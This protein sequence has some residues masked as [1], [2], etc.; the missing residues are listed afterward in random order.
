MMTVDVRFEASAQPAAGGALVVL[1]GPDG[2]LS[3]AARAADEASG[4]QLGRAI[5]AAGFA[6]KKGQLVEIVAPHGHAA[7]RLLLAGMGEPA[8]ADTRLFEDVGGAIAARLLT[9]TPSATVDLR[10]LSGLGT[11][12]AEAAAHLGLGAV[13]RAWRHDRYRTR[14][15]EEDKPKL[16]SLAIVTEAD[17]AAR[18]ADLKEVAAGVFLARELV[19][20]PGNVIYPDSFVE[21]VR[22]EVELL[23]V[24]V[25]VLDVP[26]MERLGMWSLLS[27]GQGSAK[28]ARLLAM[29]WMGGPEGAK[30]LALIGKGVTFDTGGISLKPA[31]N[32]EDMRTDMG[33]AAAVAGA[34]RALAGRKAK[35]NVVGVCGLVENMPSDRATRPGDVVTSLSG[36]TVEIINTDAEGRL[37]LIDTMTWTQRTYQPDVMIDLATLTGAMVVAVA[38]EYGGMFAND[39]TLAGQL[40]AAGLAVDDKLWRFPLS[41][42]GGHYDKMID[43]PLADMKNVGP[44]EGGSIT[45]AQFLQRV[46]ENGVKWAHLDIAGAVSRPKEGSLHGKGATGFGVRL[47][48]RFVRD[49]REG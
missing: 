7:D 6:G 29:E 26:E 36:L 45:A 21:R 35:A 47:L 15:K 30:P 9:S 5:K 44:R 40:T 25:T 38:H 48:D 24:K 42:V 43:S 18:F 16:Q 1:A 41:E 46:V 22:A 49:T 34:M 23:G 39:D 33:G 4:G 3:P 10:G 19:T 13:L 37:V 28:P 14:L 8:K 31:A 20:E 12:A 11:S 17:P 2:A 32:M 27:V